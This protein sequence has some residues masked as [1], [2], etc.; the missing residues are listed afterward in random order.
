MDEIEERV[1]EVD[2]IVRVLSPAVGW[3]SGIP[4][5]GAVRFDAD[6]G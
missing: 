2:G 5:E 1:I 4:G 6:A 3:W